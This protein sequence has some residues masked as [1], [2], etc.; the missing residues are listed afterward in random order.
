MV[1][2]SMLIRLPPALLSVI[3]RTVVVLIVIGIAWVVPIKPRRFV[4]IVAWVFAK[5]EVDTL[6]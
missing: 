5:L 6:S 4:V 1:M 2:A 3:P